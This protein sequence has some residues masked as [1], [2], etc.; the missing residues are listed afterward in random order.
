MKSF[1]VAP[2][3]PPSFRR[4]VTA[5]LG[6][7]FILATAFACLLA[8]LVALQTGSPSL[9]VSISI[10]T[11]IGV[12][13]ISA[14]TSGLG[15]TLAWPL[16][17]KARSLGMLISALLAAEGGAAVFWA[18]HAVVGKQPTTTE[19]LVAAVAGAFL[20]VLYWLLAS[21]ETRKAD[22]LSDGP[23]PL[24]SDLDSS[25]LELRLSA[26]GSADPVR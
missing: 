16:L 14:P 20:G 17:R 7:N 26:E 5:L 21:R 23:P 22:G 8:G 18:N 15:F 25:Q 10:V 24:A 1:D 11:W 2:W 3:R 13:V 9:V 6:A 19:T 12:F 4:H